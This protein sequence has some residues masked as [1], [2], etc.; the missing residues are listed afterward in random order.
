MPDDDAETTNTSCIIHTG[1]WYEKRF[2]L[3]RSAMERQDATKA[4]IEKALL[5]CNREFYPEMLSPDDTLQ[6]MQSVLR[7]SI[8]R[9]KVLGNLSRPMPRLRV[10]ATR[11][12]E[13]Y[14]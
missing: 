1:E 4:A 12:G 13:E 7:R 2:E 14:K 6:L 8:R 5:Q 3:C 11:G 9:G 10:A